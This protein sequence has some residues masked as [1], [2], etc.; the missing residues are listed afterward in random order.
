[1]AAD[2][3]PRPSGTQNLIN[4][5]RGERSTDLFERTANGAEADPS[6]ENPLTDDGW[7]YIEGLDLLAFAW[8]LGAGVT[9]ADIQVWAAIGRPSAG[10]SIGTRVFHL[11][12]F[13]QAGVTADATV[14]VLLENARVYT[15]IKL[16]LS[17]VVGGTDVTLNLVGAP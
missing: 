16:R 7:W 4:R 9:S 13:D 14:P 5:A 3:D 11:S 12:S 2:L 6:A 15:H 8:Y 1:M 17:A 10:D